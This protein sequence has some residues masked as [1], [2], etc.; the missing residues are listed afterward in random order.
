[1][2]RMRS[3]SARADRNGIGNRNPECRHDDRVC[4]PSEQRLNLGRIGFFVE[5]CWETRWL[6]ILFCKGVL[7]LRL[8]PPCHRA[9]SLTSYASDLGDLHDVLARSGRLALRAVVTSERDRFPANTTDVFR[10]RCALGK[11]P[12]AI[13]EK[14]T[15]LSPRMLRDTLAG[16]SRP[17]PKNRERL[18]AIARKLGVI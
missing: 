2:S 15:G 10:R 13:L 5:P 18:A 8:R 9:G 1:M 6:P 11:I 4:D 16:R 12:P 3:A 17:Y 14:M 7:P